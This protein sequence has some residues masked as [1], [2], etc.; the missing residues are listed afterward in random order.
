VYNLILLQNAHGSSSSDKC[1]LLYVCLYFHE[2]HMKSHSRHLK[3][4]ARRSNYSVKKSIPYNIIRASTSHTTVKCTK[5]RGGGQF[6]AHNSS[7]T[8]QYQAL[9]IN[10]VLPKYCNFHRV[11]CSN[12]NTHNIIMGTNKLQIQM[13]PEDKTVTWM[14]NTQIM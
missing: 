8:F 6:E 5:K 4:N 12:C 11:R 2:N 9:K 3:I 14:L 1:V 7:W 10:E 13:F